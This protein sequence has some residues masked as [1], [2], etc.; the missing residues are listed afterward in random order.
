MAHCSMAG[1]DGKIAATTNTTEHTWLGVK[2]LVWYAGK[3]SPV[4][5]HNVH[6]I[7]YSFQRGNV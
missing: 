5:L 6:Q 3:K 4:C 7:Y 1:A 2:V